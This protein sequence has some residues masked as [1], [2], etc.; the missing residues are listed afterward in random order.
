[1]LNHEQSQGT[2]LSAAA[3][4]EVV[5]YGTPDA[6]RNT[7]ESLLDQMRLCD[8]K[9]YEE[10]GLELESAL[11]TIDELKASIEKLENGK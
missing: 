9:S 7:L 6:M 1:M 5:R 11:E 4:D 3:I 8:W 10:L 2:Y